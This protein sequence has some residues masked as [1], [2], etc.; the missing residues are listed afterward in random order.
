[1]PAAVVAGDV[2]KASRAAGPAEIVKLELVTG[3]RVAA[4]ARSTCR[5]LNALL[6]L[7]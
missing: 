3:G 6:D 4:E 2:E 7:S 5:N 1:V